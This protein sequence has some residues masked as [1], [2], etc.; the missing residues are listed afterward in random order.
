MST[1]GQRRRAG[2]YVPAHIADH[3]AVDVLVLREVRT[4]RAEFAELRAI[5]AP[6]ACRQLSRAAQAKKAGVSRSTIYR[7]E[8]RAGAKLTLMLPAGKAAA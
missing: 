1:A 2:A 5:M 8:K 6:L 7:R 4:L 3:E